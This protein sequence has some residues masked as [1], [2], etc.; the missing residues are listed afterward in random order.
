MS[1][2]QIALDEQCTRQGW[3][4]LLA[5][6]PLTEL[7]RHW[8]EIVHPK[9]QWIRRPEYG[10]AML[11][12]AVGRT[13][14]AFNLGEATVTRCTVQIETGEIGIAYV[15]GRNKRHAALAALFDALVQRDQVKGTSTITP[16]IAAL[17]R[18]VREAEG[19][20]R[21]E[22]QQSKVDFFMLGREVT[23]E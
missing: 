2:T 19:A 6:A 12:G 10:A 4:T 15:L 14:A 16:I 17:K 3:M 21:C 20:V 23:G 22:T 18:C 1:S 5:K 13:G 7:E 9:F 11:Q 8:A